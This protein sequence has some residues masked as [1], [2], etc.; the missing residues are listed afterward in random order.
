MRKGFG[1]MNSRRRSKEEN[2]NEKGHLYIF[3]RKLGLLLI[4][5]YFK[6]I[7]T[8]KWVLLCIKTC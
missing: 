1:I 5:N 3:I 2:Q 7:L 8:K 6:V 4:F